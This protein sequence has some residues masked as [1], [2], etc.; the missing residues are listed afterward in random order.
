M[1]LLITICARGGSKGIPG[2]NIRPINGTPLITYSIRHA[3]AYA[4]KTGADIELSTDNDAIKDVAAKAGLTTDY[5]RPPALASDMAGKLETIEDI[6][7][8]AER[9]HGKHYDY[10]LDLDVTSPLRTMEDL[11]NAFAMI[12][13]N[14]AARNLFSVSFPKHNPYFDMVELKED[15][16]VGLVKKP[17]KQMVARQE[18]P[19]VYEVNAS[20]YFYRRA[21]FDEHPLIII[22]NTLA[23]EVPHMCF[24]LDDML[25]FEL[26]DYLLRE[27]KLDFRFQ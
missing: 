21:F 15:G 20:F 18:G 25:E 7:L 8:H 17:E 14:P 1:H 23:Y 3:L 16:F 27:K 22:K 13:K 6:V 11:D 10:I 24:E 5:V 26:L 2:K 4:K 9:K 19:K 12:E